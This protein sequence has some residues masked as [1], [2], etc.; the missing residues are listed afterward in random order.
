ME[1]RLLDR[2]RVSGKSIPLS[3]YELLG[4]RGTVSE[5]RL[6]VARLYEKALR[7]CWS[8]QWEESLHW[9]EEA[10]GLADRDM[11]L[12]RLA[13]RVHREQTSPPSR[14]GL[15]DSVASVFNARKQENLHE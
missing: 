3:I 12:E 13:E 10:R 14:E 1:V 6:H 4:E 11:P 2:I 8:R 5:K 9:I 7:A 15:G